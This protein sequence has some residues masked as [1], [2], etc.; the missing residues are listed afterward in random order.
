MHPT[1]KYTFIPAKDLSA[2]EILRRY[3]EVMELA[4]LDNLTSHYYP[5][6]TLSVIESHLTGHFED[7][8]SQR[9]HHRIV[10]G[11][12]GAARAAPWLERQAQP[13][14]EAAIPQGRGGRNIPH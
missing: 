3:D 14:V 4:A 10:T 9:L 6:D 1:Y 12:C 11:R 13:R 5:F 7:R 8:A 2:L